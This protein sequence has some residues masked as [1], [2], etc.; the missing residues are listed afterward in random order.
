MPESRL[1]NYRTSSTSGGLYTRLEKSIFTP[2]SKG[3]H[4]MLLQL[5]AKPGDCDRIFSYFT[6]QQV[7]F[8]DWRLG[9]VYWT[10]QVSMA[11]LVVG[12]VL[13]YKQGYLAYEQAQGAVVTHVAGDAVAVSTGRPGTRYFSTE[14]LTHPGLEN[15]NVFIATR[16]MVHRQMRGYCEDPDMPCMSDADCIDPSD[17]G[18]CT[19]QGLCRV[20]SWCN[21]ED[22]PE[23]YEMQV[24][25]LEVWARSFMQFVKLAPHRILTTD[26]MTDEPNADTVFSV[27]QLLAMVN[28]NGIAVDYDEVAHLGGLFEVAMRWECN[29]GGLFERFVSK[30]RQVRGKPA[31]CTPEVTVR[32]LD[33][34]F[35]P[36][37]IGYDFKY[38]EYIDDDHRLQNEVSGLRFLFRT[39]G[40][41][42][43]FSV[44][45]TITTVSTSGTLMS[46]AIVISD[47]FLTKGFRNRE[48][49]KARK[50]ENSPDFSEY[51]EEVE[52]KR[53]KAVK[54][55][56]IEKAEE[57]VVMRE[58][59]YLIRLNEEG[60]GPYQNEGR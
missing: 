41:G 30:V 5:S 36:D 8:L 22:T 53:R 9:L 46:L 18:V 4:G 11:I 1:P 49:F 48:K 33:T 21:V 17:K 59:A 6:R 14:E 15:G 16:L 37:N 50:F 13:I 40:L 19:E 24:D 12:Y 35:D 32:R 51:L 42:K 43:K 39:T 10:I 45:E 31:K 29:L 28:L 26:S 25:T 47:L 20:Y 44:A 34:L 52:E 56:D 38:A 58:K 60:T 54:L 7:L 23:K 2:A 3:L 57:T 27:R 55:I